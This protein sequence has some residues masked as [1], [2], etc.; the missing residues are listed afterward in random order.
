MRAELGPRIRRR[1][2]R[3]RAPPWLALHIQYPRELWVAEAEHG[4]GALTF[5]T[6]AAP[7]WGHRM[8]PLMPPNPNTPRHNTVHVSENIDRRL[9][10][11]PR[12]TSILGPS[13]CS[14]VSLRIDRRLA[15][16]RTRQRTG[17]SSGF[18]SLS[19]SPPSVVLRLPRVPPSPPPPQRVFGGGRAHA[20][21]C[22]L[23][24]VYHNH[25]APFAARD[26]HCSRRPS[27]CTEVETAPL[28]RGGPASTQPAS[29]TEEMGSYTF[30]CKS[31]PALIRPRPRALPGQG[32]FTGARKLMAGATA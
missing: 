18:P 19:S 26:R 14:S 5:P 13:S 24:Y 9:R 27:S 22:L 23:A 15:A 2:R 17:A 4:A 6:P 29:R 32:R 31:V 1:R 12:A 16:G 10:C 11:A 20:S 25:P 8:P 7:G 28:R 30:R 21:D 3:R